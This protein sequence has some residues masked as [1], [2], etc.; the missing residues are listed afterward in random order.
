MQWGSAATG[1]EG[2]LDDTTRHQSPTPV[3]AST[4]RRKVIRGRGRFRGE[5]DV[6]EL[7]THPLPATSSPTPD[8]TEL[9]DGVRAWLK[10]FRDVEEEARSPGRPVT[11]SSIRANHVLTAENDW[12]SFEEAS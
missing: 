2:F 4:P 1:L 8:A 12:G 11:A 9:Q 5:Y 6:D 10:G 3:P 7:G